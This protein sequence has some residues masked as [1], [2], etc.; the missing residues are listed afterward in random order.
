LN[1]LAARKFKASQSDRMFAALVQHMRDGMHVDRAG[2]GS[3][4]EEV[5]S[6]L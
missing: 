1:L 2:Y 5:P 6:W 4:K 3:K